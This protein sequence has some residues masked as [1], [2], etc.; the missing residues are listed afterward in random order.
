MTVSFACSGLQDS[1]N[2]CIVWKS[3]SS[4]ECL[5]L[6]SLRSTVLDW[7]ITIIDGLLMMLQVHP[8]PGFTTCGRC[9]PCSGGRTL[10][11]AAPALAGAGPLLSV[12]HPAASSRQHTAAMAKP[13]ATAGPS[14]PI[15]TRDGPPLCHKCHAAA[16]SRQLPNLT[17][18]SVL[19]ILLTRSIHPRKARP[20]SEELTLRSPPVHFSSKLQA[21]QLLQC[22]GLSLAAAGRH[23]G[24]KPPDLPRAAFA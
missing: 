1:T 19:R 22:Q 18:H 10:T 11:R 13:L 14:H 2:A 24:S 12:P 7:I 8:C 3:S 16:L 21:F 6:R 9:V 4:W 5:R 15:P 17:L 20:I 23:G